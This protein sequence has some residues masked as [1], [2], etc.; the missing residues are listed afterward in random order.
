MILPKRRVFIKD[1]T[2][3]M[4]IVQHIFSSCCNSLL[5]GPGGPDIDAARSHSDASHWVGVLST[6]DQPDAETST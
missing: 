2:Q 4:Y 1:T 5:V 3:P 6:S